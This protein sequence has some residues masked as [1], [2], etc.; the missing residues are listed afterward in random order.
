MTIT[1]LYLPLIT[2]FDD[3]GAVALGSLEALAHAALDAGAAGLV[4]LGTTAEP[5]ALSVTEQR[6]VLHV[7]ARVCRERSAPLLVGANTGEALRSLADRPEVTAALTLVPPF[8]RPGERGVLAHFAHLATVS[9]VPLVAYHIPYRTG[10]NLS[11]DAVRRLAAIPGVVGVKHAV[12]G[13]DAD[14]VALLADLPPDF[15]VLGGDDLVFSPLLAFGAHGGI[16]ASAHLA[17]EGFVALIEAWRAGETVRARPLGHRLAAQSAALF[18][19][20]NPTVVKAVLH[21]RGQIPTPAVRL[22]LLPAGADSTATALRQLAAVDDALRASGPVPPETADWTF[23][24]DRGLPGVR[25]H[26]AAGPLHRGTGCAPSCHDGGRLWPAR[27]P[28]PGPRRPSGPPSSTP[29][30]SATPA[31]SSV[32][33][34][35]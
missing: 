28:P 17:T 5:S 18:A 32:S 35:S 9:P 16:L 34:W 31:G 20:P 33:A 13:I 3:A 8:V 14:T 11:A 30:T 12:G 4:A 7:V 6:S 26:P 24:V 25:V 22:P 21:A 1:G 27:T 2:P 15:A 10:Q 19:E 23:V 29:A